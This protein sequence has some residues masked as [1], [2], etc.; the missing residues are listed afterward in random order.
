MR[1]VAV[2][3]ALVAAGSVAQFAPLL[4]LSCESSS[5]PPAPD[6]S[7]TIVSTED[8]AICACATPDCLPNCSDLP[9]CK[10]ECVTEASGTLLDWVDPCGT[11]QYTQACTTG[12]S[13]AAPSTCQ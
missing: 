5:S 3:V 6:A 12:C 10:I 1:I 2:V 7:S 8:G 4:L 11:V 9:A 13:D